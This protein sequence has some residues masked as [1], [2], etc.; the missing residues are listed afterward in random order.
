MIEEKTGIKHESPQVTYFKR[1]KGNM[2]CITL[3]DN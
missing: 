2:A 1:R 3:D